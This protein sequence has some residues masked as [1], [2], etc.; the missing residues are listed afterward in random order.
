[1]IRHVVMWKLKSEDEGESRA[2]NQQKMKIRLEK[3]EDKIPHIL[4][5]EVGTNI[6]TEDTTHD[7]VLCTEFRSLADLDAY[8]EHP[9]HR[10]VAEFIRQVTE[11]RAALDYIL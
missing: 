10:A 6:S 4:S 7:I 2:V 8:R 1:M 9:E 3:L 5:L 11:S